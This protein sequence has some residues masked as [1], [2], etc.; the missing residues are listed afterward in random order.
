MKKSRLF[1]WINYDKWLQ[2]N[3]AFYYRNTFN[4]KLSFILPFF[5]FKWYNQLYKDVIYLKTRLISAFFMILMAV[6]ILLFGGLPFKLLVV[7]LGCISLYELL[8]IRE[9]EKKFPLILK[10]FSFIILGVIMYF[11]NNNTMNYYINYKFLVLVFGFIFLPVVFINDNSKYNIN[12]ALFLIGSIVFLGITFS[13][14]IIIREGSLNYFIFLLLITIFTDTFALIS[15]RLIG[16]HKLCEKIS[17]N[18]T[19]EGSIG[20]SL[21]GTI[22]ATTFY[23][24]VINPD[25]NVFLVLIITLLFSIIGQIGDL[26]FSSIKRNY[27]VKDF[28]N[29]IPGHGGILDRFDSF[30][31]VVILYT[32]FINIL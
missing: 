9:N 8:I 17:P 20:G 5:S 15:G 4:V 31:F 22:I 13:S 12:D 19:I 14:L 11:S 32:L 23:F 25:A 29:I 28:S 30:I 7:L 21:F 3:E 26:F 10:I 27:Q 16:K 2:K 24:I 1:W 18:K 6:P